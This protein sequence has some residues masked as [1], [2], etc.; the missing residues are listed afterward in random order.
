MERNH[1]WKCAILMGIKKQITKKIVMSDNK[2]KF[3][4]EDIYF[5]DE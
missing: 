4:H 2:L 5:D 1:R 3:Q